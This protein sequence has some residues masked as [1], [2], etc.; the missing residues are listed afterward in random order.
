[1]FR[2]TAQRQQEAT[3]VS[4]SARQ[5]KEQVQ[6][7]FAT[8]LAPILREGETMPDLSLLQELI[9]RHLDSSSSAM[10]EIDGRY[11]SQL[12]SAAALRAERNELVHNLRQRMRDV[13]YLLSRSVAGGVFKAA[14]RDRK[15]SKVKPV[16]LLQG[17]RDLVATL[18]DPD[19]AVGAADPALASS[20]ATFAAALEADAASF[21]QV[22]AQLSPQDRA[23]Q[24][25]LGS[26]ISDLREASET[27][28]RCADL[29]FGLY[30]VARLDYHADRLRPKG[31]RK[32]MEEQEPPKEGPPEAVPISTN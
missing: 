15:I 21:E 9:G 6:Q 32:R 26:K 19:L 28:K 25:N 22:L 10:V 11:T 3:V 4:A 14:L 20:V 27:N 18:R 12:V 29:L 5:F 30:R 17:A 1:M 7:A 2:T 13:R 31:R 16:S 8:L 24:D 23:K